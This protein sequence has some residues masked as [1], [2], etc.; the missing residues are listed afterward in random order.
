M[1]RITKIINLFTGNRYPNKT[2]MKFW[3]WM[4]DPRQENEIDAALFK[5]WEKIPTTPSKAD[6]IALNRLRREIELMESQQSPVRQKTSRRITYVI[7]I[8]TIALITSL[9]TYYATNHF[10]ADKV[11]I[12]ECYV[13]YGQTKEIMLPDSSVVKLNA[14]SLL[15][16]PSSFE[17]ENRKVYLTGEGSFVVNKM[18]NKPFIVRTT[19]MNVE[20][21]G[22][23]FNLSNYANNDYATA[24]LKQGRVKISIPNIGGEAMFLDANQQAIYNHTTK[25]LVKKDV[26]V[27]E[28]FA[29]ENGELV[30]RQADISEIIKVIERKFD[31]TIHLTTNKH[32]HNKVNMKL[33]NNESL[34]Q[35]IDV[36][37][38]VMPD[39]KSKIENKAV[40]I[41]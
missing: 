29:W 9:S 10:S 8:A 2:K 25:S 33:L 17:G 24:T 15:I 22:T 20:V 11:E 16:Y 3:E 30:L 32:N 13:S 6:K 37:E 12:I 41:Y 31:V 40:Y 39:L 21:L 28:V 7:S 38:E 19:D 35:F 23:I 5:A 14:G 18:T 34:E 1:S 27:D 36:L 26:N 4:I